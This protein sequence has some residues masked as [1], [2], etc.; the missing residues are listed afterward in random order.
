MNL[1]TWWPR[2]LTFWSV[3]FQTTRRWI[4]LTP[5]P[6]Q[7]VYRTRLVG[8]AMGSTGP[9]RLNIL[10]LA[11]ASFVCSSLS[12]VLIIKPART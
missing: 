6:H 9:C 7:F 11:A 4:L 10:H 1:G 3:A 12:Y 8:A 5:H 2:G